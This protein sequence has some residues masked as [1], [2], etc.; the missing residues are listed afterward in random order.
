MNKTYTW[1]GL[2]TV[3]YTVVWRKIFVVWW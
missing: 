3:V 2:T 1:E